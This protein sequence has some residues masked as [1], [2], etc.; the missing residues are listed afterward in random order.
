[1]LPQSQ[2]HALVTARLMKNMLSPDYMNSYRPISNLSFKSKLVERPVASRLVGHCESN[3][4][5]SV[6]QSAYRKYHSTETA[7]T[8]VYTDI[9]R[10]VDRGQITDLVLL[11]LSSA[12]DTVDHSCLI[13]VLRQRFN[14]IVIIMFIKQS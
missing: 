5:F 6:T 10:A 8:I 9:V 2:K 13:S 4:L 7:V 14:I 3:S 11:D 12:F 1:M